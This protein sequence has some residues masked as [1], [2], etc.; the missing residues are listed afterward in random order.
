MT[1][2]SYNSN[3]KN[4]GYGGGG[5]FMSGLVS[6]IHVANN[7]VKFYNEAKTTVAEHFLRYL[8]NKTIVY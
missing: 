7:P 6:Y 5:G 1:P 2:G 3:M 4:W 8:N